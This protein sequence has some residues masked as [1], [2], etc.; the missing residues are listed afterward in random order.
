[1]KY[2]Q[3]NLDRLNNLLYINL[4]VKNIYDE[5]ISTTTAEELRIFFTRSSVDLDML[6]SVL[7][8]QIVKLGGEPKQYKSLNRFYKGVLISLKNNLEDEDA[9]ESLKYK[10][11]ELEELSINSYDA[12]LEEM[13][14]PLSVCKMLIGQRD[15]IQQR[16]YS[17]RTREILV[18]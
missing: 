4:Q 2:L 14:I 9:G 10:L 18:A 8:K 7:E 15:K 3:R 5:L 11:C 1:M 12:F 13:H 6:C 17:I 16:I